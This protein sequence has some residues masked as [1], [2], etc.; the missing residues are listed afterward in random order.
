MS[1]F[2]PWDSRSLDEWRSKY[3]PGK[4]LDIDG[5]STH[6][7]ECGQGEPVIL[8]HGF[9]QDL[10]TWIKN[11]DALARHFKVFAYDLWG[12]G[13]S[14]RQAHEYGYPLYVNQLSHFLDALG[15][16]KAHLIGHSLGGGTAIAFS[17]QNKERVNKL[18]LVDSAGIPRSL[19]FRSKIFN[20]PNV[21]ELLMSF[22]TNIIRRKTFTDL[23]I[24]DTKVLSPELFEQL[25]RFQ[26]I[27]GS[28]KA[29]LTILRKDFFNTLS[30]EIDLLRTLDIPTMVIWGEK[31]R[32]IPLET[33]VEMHRR[34]KGSRFEAFPNAGHMSN[35][36]FPAKFNQ[37]V[38]DFLRG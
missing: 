1:D 26:K 31:D 3:A 10:N 9:Y 36:E 32:N 14:T 21:G 17:A 30:T 28:S 23:W 20:L 4:I 33:G 19:P 24:Y 18:I 27:E 11:I 22:N 12:L 25:F 37:L 16:K 8:I 7:I 38:L 2:I 6:Y 13:Y 15:I 29:M 5:L 35:L 34:L